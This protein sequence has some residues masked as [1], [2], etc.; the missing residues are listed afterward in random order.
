MKKFLSMGVAVV[1]AFAMTG[2]QWCSDNLANDASCIELTHKITN[3]NR[4]DAASFVSP[5]VRVGRQVF[6]PSFRV[7]PG[8]LTVTGVGDT[9]DSA[10]YDA[11]RQFLAKA[12]CD[13]IISVSKVSD[14]KKHPTW[15]FW[16]R[17]LSWSVTISGIPL[18]LE[19][20]DV[21]E[22]DAESLKWHDCDT[23]VYKPARE[24][25]KFPDQSTRPYILPKEDVAK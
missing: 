19:K 2:C 3:D 4:P 7:G 18:Y 13:Y 21:E 1:A 14:K 17:S 22:L 25:N 16:K 9:Q 24:Y 6:R 8:R 12:N 20:L 15:R 23:G 10:T 11:I 5:N